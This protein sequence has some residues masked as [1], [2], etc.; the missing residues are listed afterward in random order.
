MPRAVCSAN[1]LRRVC[2]WEGGDHNPQPREQG[3]HLRTF[4]FS[5]SPL[6]FLAGSLTSLIYGEQSEK[7]S[8]SDISLEMEHRDKVGAGVGLG[9]VRAGAGARAS[10]G[11]SGLISR[12]FAISHP[13]TPSSVTLDKCLRLAKPVSLSEIWRY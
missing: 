1:K 7:T 10:A 6:P 11:R 12:G 4:S 9:L 2:Y 5:T 8:P 3:R 13:T